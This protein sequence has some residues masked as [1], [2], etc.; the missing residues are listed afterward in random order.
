[1]RPWRCPREWRRRRPTWWIRDRARSMTG[2]A[3]APR[4]L[5]T[6]EDAIRQLEDI[7]EFF[8]KTEPHSPLAY[9]LTDAVR[10]ARMPLPDLLAEVLPDSGARQ[11]MLTMLGSGLPRPRAADLGQATA[12]KA[13]VDGFSPESV[14]C[15]RTQ[16]TVTLVF[17]CGDRDERQRS[18]EACPGS[19]AAGPHHLRGGDRRGGRSR[20]SCPSSSACWAISPATP[21]SRS[22]RSRTASSSRS[23]AT[24]STT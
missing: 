4:A 5:R 10:R 24:T 16:E 6:R 18:P 15:R 12:G 11:A 3:A 13:F 23:T 1:M 7:A 19:Q 2:A 14:L 22:S 20:A 9:T 21:P 8:R 17:F